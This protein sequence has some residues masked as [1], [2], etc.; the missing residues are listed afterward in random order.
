MD[1]RPEEKYAKRFFEALN[2][3]VLTVP[4]GAA[5]TPEFLVNGDRS[6]YVVEVKARRDSEEWLRATKAGELAYESRPTG[7]GRWAEDVARAA[8]KQLVSADPGH[9][10]F[11]I[12][13]LSI[14]CESPGAMLDQA[15]GT[16]FGVRHVVD[17]GSTDETKPMWECLFAKPGVFERHPDVVGA[18][19]YVG[20]RI[21][22]CANERAKDYPAFCQTIL[23]RWFGDA[24][25]ST[26]L[27]QNFN[28][29]AIE[30]SSVDRKSEASITQY[31]KTKYNLKHPVLCDISAHSAT[32][33]VSDSTS[34]V[35]SKKTP[36]T[37]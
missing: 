3:S 33:F 34:G 16:L 5:K 30:D 12:L 20:S 36:T 28:F 2:L 21:Y 9:S 1:L 25:S 14:E 4:T 8:L 29:L 15:V 13:W 19:V 10:R 37:K 11:W 31:L 23:C 18:V 26:V 24:I 32:G 6:G 22:L 17:L 35:K 7:F 27:I